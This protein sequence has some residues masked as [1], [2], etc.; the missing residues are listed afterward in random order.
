VLPALAAAMDKA[1]AR[2]RGSQ[3]FAVFARAE[4]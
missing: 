2:G 3:D 1:L 4:G